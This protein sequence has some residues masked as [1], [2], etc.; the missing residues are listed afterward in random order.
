MGSVEQVAPGGDFWG[1]FACQKTASQLMHVRLH[2]T[3]QRYV[4]LNIPYILWESLWDSNF[5]VSVR[6]TLRDTC[7]ILI[8]HCV[9]P[10]LPPER[11]A[12]IS[13]CVSMHNKLVFHAYAVHTPCIFHAYHI[14]IICI[15][16]AYSIH[17]PCTSRPQQ[18]QK[19]SVL[20]E[21][22]FR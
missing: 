12:G 1:P 4:I 5:S 20:S 3:K 9:I 22:H 8:G 14:H 21:M 16:Q 7:V 15:F 19:V 11:F 17:I 18:I 2:F 6:D 13:R 10:W